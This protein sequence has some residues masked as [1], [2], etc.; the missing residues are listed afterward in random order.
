MWFFSEIVRGSLSLPAHLRNLLTAHPGR[1]QLSIAIQQ[2]FQGDECQKEKFIQIQIISVQEGWWKMHAN[3]VWSVASPTYRIS[4]QEKKIPLAHFR[5][6]TLFSL[7]V[8]KQSKCPINNSISFTNYLLKKNPFNSKVKQNWM[9]CYRLAGNNLPLWRDR[10]ALLNRA[11]L[12]LSFYG[13]LFNAYH[14]QQATG[15]SPYGWLP[16]L[17]GELNNTEGIS[18]DEDTVWDNITTEHFFL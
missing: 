13:T 10:K 3:Y 5:W 11:F 16:S 2:Q 9:L 7:T 1:H 14:D 12:Y 17:P 6:F 18:N 8:R 15:H 4:P